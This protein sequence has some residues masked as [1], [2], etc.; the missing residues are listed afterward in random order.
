M[1]A[2]SAAIYLLVDMNKIRHTVRNFI[3]KRST[4]LF[5]YLK[6]LDSEMFKY[7]GGLLKIIFITLF[8][9]SISYLVIG[10]PNALLLGFLA[11]IAVLVPYFGGMFVNLIAAVTAFVISPALFI[12]TIICFVILSWIDGYVI[13]P[14]VYGKT[15]RIH[16]L[17]VIVSVFAG[18][19][20]FGVVG[21]VLSLPLAIIIVS[22]ISYF[23]DDIIDIVDDRKNKKVKKENT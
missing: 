6:I 20:L 9:Y 4:K 19:I 8:E 14:L 1:I 22:T 17:I 15:N 16:P 5:N 18:G 11:S 7:L 12:R 10:H 2:L 21:I 13:N 3:I 23:K